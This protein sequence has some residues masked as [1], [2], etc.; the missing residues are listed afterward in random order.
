MLTL[1]HWDH[2]QELQDAGGWAQ[3]EMA[4]RFADY[5]ELVARHLGDR[6][7]L[8]IT[9]NEPWCT[10]FLGHASGVHAPGI[11][12]GATALTVAH[13]LNLAH[14]LGVQALRA[15]LPPQALIA[16]AL[17]PAPVRCIVDTAENRDAVRRA[18]ALRNRIFL[19]PLLGLDYPADLIADTAGVTDWSF[20]RDNDLKVAATAFDLL[21]INYYTPLVV[22]AGPG[23]EPDPY[24]PW[25]GSEDRLHSVRLQ[26]ASIHGLADAHGLRDLLLRIRRDYPPVPVIIA[27]N[28]VA[29]PDEIGPDG[30]VDDAARIAYMHA[31]LVALHEA[32]NSGVDVRGYITWSLMDNFEWVYGYAQKFGLIHVDRA[33]QIRTVKRSGH[34]Y[35]QVIAANAVPSLPD[36]AG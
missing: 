34:W 8:W 35:R 32:I 31:H 13:H 15:V 16:A 18:D 10:A 23:E 26:G 4:E 1:Y 36:P 17:N 27:E 11:A 6:V 24:N 14:G 28:G 19:D 7:P 22:A 2:P 20:V 29:S 9:L 33:T 25:I 12:D 5:A 21:G 3:R 30:T